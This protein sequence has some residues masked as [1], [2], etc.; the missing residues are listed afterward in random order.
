MGYFA[1]YLSRPDYR[2]KFGLP[3]IRFP[4]V[5]GLEELA[6]TGVEALLTRAEEGAPGPGSGHS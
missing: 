3:E 1:R 6:C 4:A 5:P 2:I